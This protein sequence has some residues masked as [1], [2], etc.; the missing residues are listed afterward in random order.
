M[1]DRV[2]LTIRD[3]PMR[4][5]VTLT[6]VLSSSA[7]DVRT[8]PE[9]VL[10]LDVSRDVAATRMIAAVG[11]VALVSTVSDRDVARDTYQEVVEHLRDPALL[12]RSAALGDG[13]RLMLH[14]FPVLRD[15]PA[16]VTI[17]LWFPRDDQL[18]LDPGPR[19]IPS[20]SIDTSGRSSDAG[21]LA[22]PLVI[23]LHDVA[24]LT[25]PAKHAPKVDG[26][27]SL[28]AAPSF[29]GCYAGRRPPRLPQYADLRSAVDAY[30]TPF[31][32]CFARGRQRDPELS[33][34]VTL[35][36]YVAGNGS[37]IES[38]LDGVAADIANCITDY[39][40]FWRFTP[41]GRTEALRHTFERADAGQ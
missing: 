28:I 38:H 1:L 6:L 35:A 34:H 18:E 26:D 24:P 29:H 13:E 11:D 2:A 7:E 8:A 37:V 30:S 20:I 25:G 22:S 3:A 32:Q 14:V 17:E 36:V 16:T 21:T 31:E 10:P 27:R 19:A 23:A 12:E 33:G 15:H 41:T 9:L 5:H 40:D 4:T 39:V